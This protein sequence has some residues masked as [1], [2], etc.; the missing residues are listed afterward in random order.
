[1]YINRSLLSRREEELSVLEESK[2]DLQRSLRQL[3]SDAGKIRDMLRTEQQALQTAQKERRDYA[4]HVK[5]AA[6]E[7]KGE[8]ERKE[9]EL[10]KKITDLTRGVFAGDKDYD[11]M[12]S[13]LERMTAR[14]SKLEGKK[15]QVIHSSIRVAILHLIYIC[16][17]L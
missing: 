4:R 13:E 14:A 1:M 15:V 11:N 5:R 3:D 10:R 6:D 9:R 2:E 8:F 16:F 12:R 7:S 17:M